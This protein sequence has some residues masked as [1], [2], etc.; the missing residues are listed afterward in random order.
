[1]QIHLGKQASLSQAQPQ[2]MGGSIH[3]GMVDASKQL[4]AI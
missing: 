4:A 3:S 2:A 1:M